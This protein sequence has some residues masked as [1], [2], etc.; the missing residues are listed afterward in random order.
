MSDCGNRHLGVAVCGVLCLLF[1]VASMRDAV[2]GKG[3]AYD[4]V[5]HI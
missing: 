2:S 4:S 1:S 3:G 5:G